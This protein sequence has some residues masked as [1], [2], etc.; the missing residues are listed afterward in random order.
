[1]KEKKTPNAPDGEQLSEGGIFHSNECVCRG[2]VG[3]ITAGPFQVTK[4]NKNF[5]KTAINGN[6]KVFTL[7]ARRASIYGLLEVFEPLLKVATLTGF[8]PVLPP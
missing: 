3:I 5:T 2:L 8:E 6:L 7:I 1:M 4:G